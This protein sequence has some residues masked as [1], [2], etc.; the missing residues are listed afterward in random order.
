[1]NALPRHKSRPACPSPRRSEAAVRPLLIVET[2]VCDLGLVP[3]T[4]GF[5]L[6]ATARSP[7]AL[8]Q[9]TPMMPA[10][11]ALL[12]DLAAWLS[13]LRRLGMGMPRIVRT[14]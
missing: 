1:M 7:I 10:L 3:V 14:H 5:N 8:D 9:N 2:Y 4:R 13:L 12:S 11:R 6:P